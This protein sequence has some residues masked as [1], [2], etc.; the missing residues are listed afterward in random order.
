MVK[1]DI[2]ASCG[3][4]SECGFYVE[5]ELT[6]EAFSAFYSGA[7]VINNTDAAP[8]SILA[9]PNV[10]VA[11]VNYTDAENGWKRLRAEF[12]LNATAGFNYG[13][14]VLYQNPPEDVA[15]TV[16]VDNATFYGVANAVS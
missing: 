15:G 6:D 3:L 5:F 16:L 13:A 1:P 8:S 7:V 11:S 10:V 4:E 14:I 12:Q 9:D 2:T